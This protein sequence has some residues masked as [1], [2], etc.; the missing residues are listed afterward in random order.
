MDYKSSCFNY[1]YKCDDGCLRMYNSMVGTRSL[2]KVEAKHSESVCAVLSGQLS[3]NYLP[4]N[5]KTVA[6][7][8]KINAE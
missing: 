5:I 6:V 4:E 8:S 3:Y 7:A 2:L 1:A